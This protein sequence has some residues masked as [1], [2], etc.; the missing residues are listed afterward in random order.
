MLYNVPTHTDNWLPFTPRLVVASYLNMTLLTETKPHRII[1]TYNVSNPYGR[2][3][4]E[5]KLAKSGYYP[6]EEEELK[7]YSA[8]KGIALGLVFLPLALLGG[9]KKVRVTYEHRPS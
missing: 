9:V 7:K 3:L 2:K 1:K 4:E 5:K 8:G 6:V